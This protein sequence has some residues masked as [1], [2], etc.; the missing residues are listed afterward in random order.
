MKTVKNNNLQI[1]IDGKAYKASLTKSY[2]YYRANHAQV[3]YVI[4]HPKYKKALT[5]VNGHAVFDAPKRISNKYYI[6]KDGQ[7]YQVTNK[8]LGSA[9]ILKPTEK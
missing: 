8:Q 4:N 1:V 7:Q 6:K 5:T 2:R 9:T 3:K